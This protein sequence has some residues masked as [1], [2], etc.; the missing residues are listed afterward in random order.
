MSPKVWWCFTFLWDC[1]VAR[2][3]ADPYHKDVRTTIA[4][5]A[6]LDTLSAG[7]QFERAFLEDERSKA[8]MPGRRP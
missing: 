2:R 8:R 4:Y 7:R 1:Y 3:F 5:Y 6:E